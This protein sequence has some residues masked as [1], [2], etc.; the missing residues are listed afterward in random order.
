MNFCVHIDTGSEVHGYF[1]PD[2]YSTVPKIHV[3][4][5]DESDVREIH[6]WVFIEG[7]RA[8]GAHE[9]GNVGF[10][11]SEANVPGLTNALSLQLS[12]PETGL[13]FYRRAQVGQYIPKKVLR[14]ETGYVPQREIDIS[15]KHHFQF[16]EQQ[17]EHHGFETIRQMLE[18]IHQ[19]S[20]Y[21]AGRIPLKN[22]RVYIDYNIDTTLI[23]LRDPFV[24]LATRL[25]VFSRVKTTKFSFVSPRDMMI[26]KPVIDW[27]DGVDMKD[28]A[29]V[30][31]A[32]LNAPA[33]TLNLLSSPFTHQLVAASPA[34]TVRLEDVSQALDRL[35]QF[36]VFDSGRDYLSYPRSIAA[37][38]D[39][40]PT[41]ISVKP[42]LDAISDLSDAIRKLGRV[43]HIL[44]VDL[45]LYHFIEKAEKRAFDGQT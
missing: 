19:P 28:E 40:A 4:L 8:Q 9:T 6:T 2:G 39:L 44:E 24:E 27:F 17:I 18:I 21:V 22:F 12:D 23:S 11:L 3:R 15:L 42:P 20:V 37:A 41:E 14:I 25:A 26:F 7:A 30:V 36:T 5:D 38:L 33:D 13:V 34:D 29:A 1:V 10:V 32:I 16:F 35:S 43:E 31:K 45:V